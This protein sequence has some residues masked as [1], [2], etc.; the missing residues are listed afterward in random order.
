M[1]SAQTVATATETI[2]HNL[3]R[4]LDEHQHH[5]TQ[6]GVCTA[7]CHFLTRYGD[8][9]QQA[10]DYDPDDPKMLVRSFECN[11]CGLCTQ[12][13]PDGL[14]PA[15]MF[16]EMRREAFTR[17][18][19]DLPEHRGLRTYERTGNTKTYSWYALPTGCDTVFFPGCALV[20]SRADTTG[21]LFEHLQQIIPA[22]GIVLDCCNKPSHDLGDDHLF[23]VMFDELR[24]YLTAHGIKTVLV[25]CPNC[26]RVFAQYAPELTTRTVYEILAE[27]PPAPSLT[28]TVRTSLV[29]VHDPC[30]TRSDATVQDAV[31]QLL[32][33]AGALIEEMPHSREKTICCG[34]GGGTSCLVPEQS[35][36]WIDQRLEE[37]QGR[38]IVSYCAGC[39]SSFSRKTTAGHV[40]D[41]IFQPQTALTAKHKVTKAPFTYLRRL[42]F[43]KRLQRHFPAATT[44][45]RTLVPPPAR[46]PRSIAIV[47]L[48]LNGVIAGVSLLQVIHQKIHNYSPLFKKSS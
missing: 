5:C 7:E 11:L 6:C 23:S 18:L 26:S 28:K 21:K 29:T 15:R 25:A 19:S 27:H 20:G 12:V 47:A 37:A 45:E 31:R 10:T 34:E 42:Q 2:N 16:L 40:L 44:R 35:Q 4:E 14:D 13:C 36:Q 46:K 39:T 17:G 8:P 1:P 48:F 43:K 9:L 22:V 41:L 3:R 30:V 24:N 32:S 33:K 38:S